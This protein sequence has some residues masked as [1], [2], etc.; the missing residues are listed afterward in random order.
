MGIDLTEILPVEVKCFELLRSFDEEKESKNHVLMNLMQQV[1]FVERINNMLS[2]GVEHMVNSKNSFMVK[3]NA[4]Q[5][6]Y[7]ALSIL[8]RAPKLII[9]NIDT[10]NAI[11]PNDM[12][13][14]NAF[15]IIDAADDYSP[16]GFVAP[17]RA[18]NLRSLQKNKDKVL[19]WLYERLPDGQQDFN[20]IDEADEELNDKLLMLYLLE[21]Q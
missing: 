1:K 21:H 6:R 10:V 3:N 13:R 14:L 20:N 11:I 7:D 17:Q 9:N 8:K 12:V 16:F 18:H 4:C 15:G 2:N 5:L 19:R